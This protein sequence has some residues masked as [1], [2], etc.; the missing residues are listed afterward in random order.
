MK[1]RNTDFLKNNKESESG[2]HEKQFKKLNHP[3]EKSFDKSNDFSLSLLGVLR[4]ANLD[5][6]IENRISLK[7]RKQNINKKILKEFLKHELPKL[8]VYHQKP[9]VLKKKGKQKKQSISLKNYIK[10][11]SSI[12]NEHFQINQTYELFNNKFILIQPIIIWALMSK[13]LFFYFFLKY[14]KGFFLILGTEYITN[15]SKIFMN[16]KYSDGNLL[17]ILQLYKEFN[18]QL[19]THGTINERVKNEINNLQH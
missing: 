7:K 12:N 9:V 4:K 5:S 2:T 14:L 6:S 1:N 13:A 10:N 15:L 17:S 18:D 11:L 19:N 16:I 3:V 8:S